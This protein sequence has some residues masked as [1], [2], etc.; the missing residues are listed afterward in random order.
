MTTARQVEQRWN[1]RRAV[2]FEV[3]LNADGQPPQQA[4]CRDL[5]FGGMYVE[6]DPQ[7]ISLN[8]GLYID[9][10]LGNSG[11]Q[12]D[13]PI[14]ARVVRIGAEGAG[15]MFSGFKLENVKTLRDAIYGRERG[16]SPAHG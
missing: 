15:L 10:H 7:A 1:E 16:Q 6:I 2:Q 14:P 12:K 4:V 3:N 11:Q 5:G 13:H 8:E 9:L